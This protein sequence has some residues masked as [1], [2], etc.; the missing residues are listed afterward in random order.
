[1]N[2]WRRQLVGNRTVSEWGNTFG[3]T[4]EDFQR[5]LLCSPQKSIASSRPLSSMFYYDIKIGLCIFSSHSS[6]PTWKIPQAT[7]PGG[8][9][10]MGSQ[11]RTRLSSH[12]HKHT[13]SPPRN[14]PSLKRW[15]AHFEL[16]PVFFL[17]HHPLIPIF[18]LEAIH[19]VIFKYLTLSCISLWFFGFDM[20]LEVSIW[21]LSP[22]T[23]HITFYEDILFVCNHLKKFATY[24]R[25]SYRVLALSATRTSLLPD[26]LHFSNFIH[27]ELVLQVQRYN[28]TLTT[29]ELLRWSLSFLPT[30]I[31]LYSHFAN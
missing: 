14:T 31:F 10:S 5:L 30:E 16:E 18:S 9:Q 2:V 22:F 3:I 13:F 23:I 17:G 1:M 12:K 8:L 25:T 7:E 6:I 11:S 19:P 4:L 24:N 21:V 28:L 15:R 27:E 29:T 20:V 26:T